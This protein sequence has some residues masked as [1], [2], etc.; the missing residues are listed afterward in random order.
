M[1]Y[2]FD[3]EKFVEDMKG[4]DLADILSRTISQSS[5]AMRASTGRGA[6]AARKKGCV[7]FSFALDDL[8]EFLMT[9][10]FSHR[11][12]KW[13]ARLFCDLLKDLVDR[14]ELAEMPQGIDRQIDLLP[15]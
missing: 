12:K 1:E 7:E 11:T 8:Q 10:T 6:P 14:G 4:R 13:H 2:D 5:T 9:H 3:I 15:F